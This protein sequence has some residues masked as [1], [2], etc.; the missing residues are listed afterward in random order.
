MR[1]T[2][3]IWFEKGEGEKSCH[4]STGIKPNFE[5]LIQTGSDC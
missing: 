1:G 4:P 2:V 3:W 5:S